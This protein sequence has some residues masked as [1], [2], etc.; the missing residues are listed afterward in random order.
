MLS[1]VQKNLPCVLYVIR[2]FH[3]YENV[4]CDLWV[5]TSFQR[6]V[7]STAYKICGIITQNTTI[8]TNCLL[9]TVSSFQFDVMVT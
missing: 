4:D 1:T 2:G 5:V 9:K 8:V 3:V 7:R 6:N